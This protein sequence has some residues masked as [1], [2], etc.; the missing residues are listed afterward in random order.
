M[1]PTVISGR[2][3]A[4]GIKSEPYL[5]CRT[6]LFE[7]GMMRDVIEC[8]FVVYH[9]AMVCYQGIGSL[10]YGRNGTKKL[11]VYGFLGVTE[12]NKGFRF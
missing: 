9:E 5:S 1:Y 2:R 6:G 11:T 3:L 4:R 7:D 8:L 10:D 12:E